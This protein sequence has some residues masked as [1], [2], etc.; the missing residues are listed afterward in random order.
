[1]PTRKHSPE[2]KRLLRDISF[3]NRTAAILQEPNPHPLRIAR[4]KAKVTQAELGK[5]AYLSRRA[6]GEA[7]RGKRKPN[8]NSRKRI[9][10]ALNLKE[11]ELWPS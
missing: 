6:V 7:E 4:V 1:M 3:E 5:L 9:A 11:S 10:L 2:V 8:S